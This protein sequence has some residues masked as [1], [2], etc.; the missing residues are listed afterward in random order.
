MPGNGSQPGYARSG[1]RLGN[2]A[3]RSG[4]SGP[5]RAGSLPGRFRATGPL[6][7]RARYLCTTRNAHSRYLD[8]ADDPQ[9]IFYRPGRKSDR[10]RL[11][12]ASAEGATAEC[13]D[14][15]ILIWVLPLEAESRS[16][17]LDMVRRERAAKPRPSS[18]R[19][20]SKQEPGIMRIPALRLCDPL[21]GPRAGKRPLAPDRRR[22]LRASR[23][24]PDLDASASGGGRM[25]DQPRAS[26]PSGAST[27]PVVQARR[28]PR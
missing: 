12:A 17:H 25:P 21:A 2:P 8:V 1:T 23:R 26:Q 3:I 6:R 11:R 7:E 15:N 5:E 4:R 18:T 9:S 24:R 20:T 13:W 28:H 22:R 27:P 14:Q 16:R 10:C 19:T